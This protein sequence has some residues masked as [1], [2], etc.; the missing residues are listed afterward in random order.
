MLQRN[1]DPLARNYDG[2][3]AGFLR[4]QTHE[5]P[6][7]VHFR[8][9]VG[10]GSGVD[11]FTHLIHPYP[12]KLLLSIPQFFLNCTEFGVPGQV[13]YDPFCGSGTV[14]LE[15]IISGRKA[16]G[17][18]TN[19]LARLITAA[20]T[21]PIQISLV[22]EY[23]D[24]VVRCLPKK[25][26]GPPHGALDLGR[27]FS[28]TV[29]RQLD[30]LSTDIR[31]LPNGPERTFVEV[32]FS[33]TLMKA[34]LADP[35]VSVPVLLN[36]QKRGLTRAQRRLRRKWVDERSRAKVIRLFSEITLANIVR[37]QRLAD[38]IAP[39]SPVELCTDAGARKRA[40]LILRVRV[41]PQSQE[42]QQIVQIY[43]PIPLCVE[44]QT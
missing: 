26:E 42:M 23:L 17:C 7:R 25:G 40:N 8:E 34:S 30:R 5:R 36:P 12:A 6:V 1:F 32:C 13:V 24:F 16:L 41:G 18:D 14:L 15:A 10:V 22:Q 44:I 29:L 37:M 19:P 2:I 39:L 11:R 28:A 3:L 43:L 21:T 33:A 38:Y 31:E 9:L 35:T 4:E 27:W 20:K